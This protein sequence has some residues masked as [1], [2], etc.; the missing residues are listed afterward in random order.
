MRTTSIIKLSAAVI[1]TLAAAAA[2][3]IFASAVSP[4]F[5]A[6]D[7]V[8]VQRDTQDASTIEPLEV[9]LFVDLASNIL[10][11]T[12]VMSPPR[13]GNVNTVDEVPNSS[14]FTNRLGLRQLTPEDVA[15]G[16]NTT[17][18]PASGGWTITSSKS[19][20]VTP[21][22]TV[23]DSSGQRWFLKFDPPGHRGMATGTEVVV[24]K[25]MWALGYNVPE[26]HIAYVRE[27]QLAIGEGAKFTP[28]GRNPRPLRR[29]D[30]ENLLQRA[31]REHDG[32]YRVIASKALSGKP[33]GR[34]KFIGTR[35]DDPNDIVPHQDRRELRAYGIFAAWLNH[36]D[37]KAI[38]S[39]DVLITENGRSYVRH[40][41]LDFGSALGSGGV[42]PADYWA[43]SEYLVEPRQ[44]AKQMVG[45][46]FNVPKCRKMPFYEARSIGRLPLHNEDFDPELW[47]PRVPNQAFL[48]ARLD[49]KFWAAQK[50]VALTTDM[51]RAAV[52][53]GK[54]DDPA[55]EDF[56]VRALAAR[57]D[58]I[59]RTYLPA[60]N[61][62]SNPSLDVDGTLTFANAAVDNDF[63]RAPRGYRA[64]WSTFDNTT[65]ATK[66]VGETSDVV[67]ELCAPVGIP[68]TKGAFIKVDLSAMSSHRS[69]AE[70]VSAYFRRGDGEW[71]LVG[72]DRNIGPSF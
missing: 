38:N 34:V 32:S 66:L 19:D 46:G 45:F 70:P 22:F 10:R 72:F 37:A 23:K 14:W 43:G 16:P 47:K 65:G 2:A 59:G 15:T 13:A 52:R 48:H 35:P 8:W 6:D 62:I 12:E 42:A 17:P 67:S 53:T 4:K 31:N 9:D 25:L 7:P 54:F 60:I 21:G 49:D 63:A 68:R 29:G 61:P 1:G 71:K 55:A 64:I 33:I 58:A 5:Y 20:G 39:L 69:W 57:R 27:E 24:T 26:N 18:G 30:I 36:V 11:G 44:V 41:L 51:I 40:Y 3:T 56:L 50:L 28:S